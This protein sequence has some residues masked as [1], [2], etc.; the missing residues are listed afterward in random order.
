MDFKRFSQE[1]DIYYFQ[2]NTY[3][4]ASIISLLNYM[5]E[6]ALSHTESIGLGIDKLRA[7]GVAWILNRWSLKI[8]RYPSWKDRIRIETW[9]SHFQ[10]FYATR[11]FYIKDKN[12]KIIGRA[13]SLWVYLNI[14][15]KRPVRIPEYYGEAYGINHHRAL[16][17]PFG[18]L[19]SVKDIKHKKDFMV[20]R[21]DIDTNNHVNNSKY[22]NWIVE[23]VP[24]EIYEKFIPSSLEIKYKKETG[25]GSSVV[26]GYADEKKSESSC[27]FRHVI[28]DKDSN[29]ELAV[30]RTIWKKRV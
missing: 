16:D 10:R 1:F 22:V 18:E 6:T 24:L 15:R 8:D 30:A 17:D 2:T 29:S 27:I 4:E 25:Y 28:T 14:E 20:R 19:V 26:C 9:P 11:E 5:E 3:Q 21:D 13:T 12:E 23:T 7:K